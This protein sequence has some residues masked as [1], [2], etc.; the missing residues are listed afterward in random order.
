[1]SIVTNECFDKWCAEL[2]VKHGI[3][4]QITD[5]DDI[6]DDIRMEYLEQLYEKGALIKPQPLEYDPA[7]IR[8]PTFGGIVPMEPKVII[9]LPVTE[10][11][12]KKSLLK[13]LIDWFKKQYAM[14]LLLKHCGYCVKKKGKLYCES[15]ARMSDD[16]ACNP[17]ECFL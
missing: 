15:P 14:Y 9:P 8:M 6:G 1:M 7:A 13:R 2:C 16:R 17:K 5:W 4:K 10:I 11:K 12:T 3:I